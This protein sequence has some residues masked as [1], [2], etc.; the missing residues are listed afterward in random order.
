M[1]ANQILTSLKLPVNSANRAYCSRLSNIYTLL[2]EITNDF[3]ISKILDRDPELNQ[4][5]IT[6]LTDRSEYRFSIP[7]DNAFYYEVCKLLRLPYN[8]LGVEKTTE[9]KGI[10]V[11]RDI[12]LS[13]KKAAKFVCT[14]P[15]RFNLNCV[16]LDF[17]KDGLKVVGTDGYLLYM[18]KNYDYLGINKQILLSKESLKTVLSL[19]PKGEKVAIEVPGNEDYIFIDGIRLAIET[20]ARFPD[21]KVILPK[22]DLKMNFDKVKFISN[23]K[24]VLPC[25]N[26]YCPTVKFHLNGNIKMTASDVDFGVE[27]EKTMPYVR[28]YFKDMDI[29]LNGKHLLKGMGIFKTK[30]LNMYSDGNSK[31]CVMFT[32]EVDTLLM[33]PILNQN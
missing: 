27:T 11:D 20:D 17:T 33:M 2:S 16:C 13:I 5:K 4:H 1:K 29:S 32:D 12:L 3:F 9:N 15:L 25:S 6:V 24:S 28:K 14:N 18:S 7:A 26:K 31:R 30:E 22:Y 21:Y 10:A 8:V 23:V 19:N